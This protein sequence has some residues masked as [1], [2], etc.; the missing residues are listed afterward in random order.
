MKFTCSTCGEEHDLANVT[1]GTEAPDQWS[2]LTEDERQ[3]SE[4]GGEQCV[5]KTNSEEGYFVRAL[6]EIPVQSRNQVFTWGVWCSLSKKSFLEVADHWHDDNRV[7]TGP[8]FGWLC[9]SIPGYAPTMFLKCQVHQQAVGIRPL[10][11][12]EATDHELSLHQR[13]GITIGE[14]QQIIAGIL[15]A[16]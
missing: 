16:A 11:E 4:L 2:K 5:I 3:A 8:N 13:N 6:L 10:V 15:H 1:F 12:L 14:L 9:T 7:N